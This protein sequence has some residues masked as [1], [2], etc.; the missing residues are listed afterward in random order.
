MVS[1][2]YAD[3]VAVCSNNFLLVKWLFNAKVVFIGYAV[4]QNYVFIVFQSEAT[5][6]IS[7]DLLIEHIKE[8]IVMKIFM[9]FRT[10]FNYMAYISDCLIEICNTRTISFWLSHPFFLTI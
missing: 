8:T 2:S 5:R 3:S 6:N 4:K 10:N 1:Y 7:H 9:Q